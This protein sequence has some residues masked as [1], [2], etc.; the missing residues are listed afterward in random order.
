MSFE[1]SDLIDLEKT[2]QLLEN[3]SK[4]VGIPAAIIDLEGKILVTSPWQR[5]CTDFHQQNATTCARCVESDTVLA[6][7]L[8]AGKSFTLFTCLNG[9]TVAASPITIEGKH[10]ANA[11]VTQFF[12]E[13]PDR[14]FFRRQAAVFGFDRV[15]YMDAVAQVPMV[16]NESLPSIL[17]FLTSFAEMI[18]SLGLKQLRQLEIGRELRNTQT[19]LETQNRQLRSARNDLQLKNEELA[20]AEEELRAQNEELRV[21]EEELRTRYE[22]LQLKNEEL[23]TIEEELR[24]QNEE[25][26]QANERIEFLARFPAENPNPVLRIRTDGRILY[27]NKAASALLAVWKSKS[28]SPKFL[29]GLVNNAFKKGS[30]RSHDIEVLDRVFSLSVVPVLEAGYVN[31]YGRDITNRK[32]AETQK[33][34]LIDILQAMNGTGDLHSQL[35]EAMAMIRKA[36]GFDAVGLRL[37]VGDDY[38][39]FEQNGFSQEFLVEENF[40][41][42]RGSDAGIIRDADGRAELECTCGLVLAGRTNPAMPYFTEGGS[43]WTNRSNELLALPPESDPRTSPRNRCIHAGYQSVGLFPVRAGREIVG[44]LQLNHLKQGRFPPESIWFYEG[45][46]RNIGLAIQ[47]VTAEEALRKSEAQFKL[48]SEIAGNLLASDNPQGIVDELCRHVMTNL[49][50]QAFFNFLV[51]EGVRK[52]H[53]NAYAGIPDEEAKKI[54]WLDFGVAVCGCA[55]REGERIVA[56]DIFN[57]PDVRTDLVKSYGIQAYACHPLKV[58]DRVIGTLSFGT[59]TRPCFSPDEL[60]LMKAVADQVAIAMERIRLIESLRKSAG[61][62]E[63]RVY[64]RTRAFQ[65]LSECNQAML[66]TTDEMELFRQ[67]CRIIVD[68][69][70]YRMAWVGLAENDEAKTVRPAASAGYE[71]GYL[72]QAQISWA[73]NEHGL[74]PTGTAIRSGKIIASQNHLLNPAYGPWRQEGAKRGYAASIALPLKIDDRVIG[75]LTMYASQPDAFYQEEADLLAKLADNLAFGVGAI[76]LAQQRR[77][78]EEELRAIPS[79]LIESQEKERKRLASELHDSIGQT[80]SALKFRVE[81]IIDT[82]RRGKTED[83]VKAAENFI[84]VLQRSIDETRAIYM[85]LRPLQLEEFGVVAALLWYREEMLRLYPERHIETYIS[86]EEGQIPERLAVPI[87]RVAQEAL[88][89]VAKHSRAEWVDLSL[90][91][92]GDAIELVVADDGKGMDVERIIQST[93]AKSLGLIGMRERTEMFG[94][95]LCIESTL[96]KGTTVRAYWPV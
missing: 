65:S 49:D 13:D 76:R 57:T 43:F 21:I 23:S 77:R 40:L 91:L 2:R 56:E 64:E 90:A 4:M 22:E 28:H 70:G 73:E 39:Y 19:E 68:V 26:Y 11:F 14:D 5:V 82:L 7:N 24:A 71:E 95:G 31:I 85:G 46:A 17:S 94:G 1:L 33:G 52:L 32:R 83:G 51:E 74:G 12:T 61:E 79:K 96:G 37:R 18:G 72:D 35:A 34:L 80:L 63:T 48:L 66:R 41:C 62:L 30:P 58:A 60:E 84:P 42:A 92:N 25:L 15:A 69:G 78:S 36:T 10:L 3:F 45:V 16:S 8:P 81:H 89:N 67:V 87:F 29:R 54:E 44:L 59:T 6:N 53:L 38:P 9:L 88:N 55:A 93:T 47:R 86:V 50:C 27:S 75:A 20:A